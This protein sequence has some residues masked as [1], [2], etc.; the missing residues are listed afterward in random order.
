MAALR[1][2][3][4]PLN[5][6]LMKYLKFGPEIGSRMLTMAANPETPT[7]MNDKQAAVGREFIN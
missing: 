7:I 6:P 1:K 2:F 5:P 3:P 4:Q